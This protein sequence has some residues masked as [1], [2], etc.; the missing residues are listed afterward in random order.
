M[1]KSVF[2]TKRPDLAILA[3]CFRSRCDAS[4]ASETKQVA[5]W[6]K[7]NRFLSLL[8]GHATATK[9]QQQWALR[10]L[11]WGSGQSGLA[12]D[13]E[14]RCC[15]KKRA[16]RLKEL[17]LLV[18]AKATRLACF[19]TVSAAGLAPASLAFFFFF[20]SLCGRW[21]CPSCI[22]CIGR[23]GH[24][25]KESQRRMPCKP[26]CPTLGASELGLFLGNC[27][28]LLGS[29]IAGKCDS[30]ATPNQK[31]DSTSNTTLCPALF[32]SSCRRP[33]ILRRHFFSVLAAGC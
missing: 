23:I 15:G 30:H 13:T 29:R 10:S 14:H 24:I 2:A 31:Q 19:S 33:F 21:S 7:T 32:C 16:S 1:N 8:V 9:P 3:S 6:D 4:T 5:C 22:G 26:L 11:G 28:R 18:H 20:L 17:P 12:R 25:V 27:E